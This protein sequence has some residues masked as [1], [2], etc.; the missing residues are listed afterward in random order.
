MSN[1]WIKQLANQEHKN[2]RNHSIQ[3]NQSGLK[4]ISVQ[5]ILAQL[6]NSGK[7]KFLNSLKD[8]QNPKITEQT[9]HNK[10]ENKQSQSS[11]RNLKMDKY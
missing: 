7:L 1:I 8:T 3:R 2:R 11:D 5:S 4:D 10:I 6:Q 9:S